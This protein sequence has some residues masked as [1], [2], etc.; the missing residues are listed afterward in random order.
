MMI[1]D[2]HNGLVRFIWY[3]RTCEL[4]DPGRPPKHRFTAHHVWFSP[5]AGLICPLRTRAA[6]KNRLTLA[7]FTVLIP[8]PLYLPPSSFSS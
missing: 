7:A 6:Y 5:L 1:K 4:P 2:K 8:L 3:L